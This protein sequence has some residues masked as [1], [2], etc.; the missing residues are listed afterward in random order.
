MRRVDCRA[1]MV[2][3]A[4]V[5]VLSDFVVYH[6]ASKGFRVD[7]EGMA[8]TCAVLARVWALEND[9]IMAT[10][11]LDIDSVAAFGA[12]YGKHLGVFFNSEGRA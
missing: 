12:R 6:Y 3:V 10:F 5:R 9:G 1:M 2:P 11:E 4:L 8:E 7:P